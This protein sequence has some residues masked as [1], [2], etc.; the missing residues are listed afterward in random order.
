MRAVHKVCGWTSSATSNGMEASCCFLDLQN[1]LH[2]WG[3]F[4]FFFSFVTNGKRHFLSLQRHN[5]SLSLANLRRIF[6]FFWKCQWWNCLTHNN[7]PFCAVTVG[8]LRVLAEISAAYVMNIHFVVSVG[9]VYYAVWKLKAIVEI[10]LWHASQQQ[11][12]NPF[13]NSQYSDD[14]LI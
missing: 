8:A 2:C 13:K 6:T 4:V 10:L 1:V 5:F 9:L 14:W 12:T 11:H 3:I 7:Y